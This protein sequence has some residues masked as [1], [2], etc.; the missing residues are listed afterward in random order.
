MIDYI[1]GK[2]QNPDEFGGLPIQH[3][4]LLKMREKVLLLL[5]FLLLIGCMLPP[6]D[7][8]WDNYMVPKWY[9]TITALLALVAFICYSKRVG[10]PLKWDTDKL[11]LVISIIVGFELLYVICQWIEH[12]DYIIT[13]TFDNPAGLALF[14]SVL[15]VSSAVLLQKS[16][17][18]N[19]HIKRI[20]RVTPITCLCIIIISKSRTG[21][22]VACIAL[23]IWILYK[24]QSSTRVKAPAIALIIVCIGTIVVANKQDSTIGR[25]FILQR[26]WDL[27]KEKPFLGH[28]HNGFRKEYMLRQAKYFMQNKESKY[29]IMADEIRHPL[30]EFL[31]VW[32]D[33]GLIGLLV[34][35]GF[36]IVPFVFC[37]EILPKLLSGV[38]FLFSLFSFPFAYPIS[39]VVAILILSFSLKPIWVKLFGMIPYF[40]S[41]TVWCGG[42][43]YLLFFL[44]VDI[45]FS[46][47]AVSASHHSHSNAIK[48]YQQIENSPFLWNKTEF[49]YNY[50]YELYQYKDFTKAYEAAKKCQSTWN[51][52]NLE[53]LMGD[54]S[55]HRD[56]NQWKEKAILH[57][58]TAFLM[59]PSRFAPLEG[60]YHAYLI[61]GDTI[62]ANEIVK[63]VRM[64][65]VKVPSSHIYRIKNELKEYTIK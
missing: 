50:A 14:A 43:I 15:G 8:C 28:G 27:I 51:G 62:H 37:K 59:C 26:T 64:K 9:V 6:I 55:V 56:G 36:F 20:L 47:A 54:I 52:Y 5:Q 22:I 24:W 23:T 40:L 58:K 25:Y 16:N 53:L 4:D 60:L 42:S 21:L 19:K 57:Y 10:K 65:R 7:Y 33:Y 34:F 41:A 13:G 11:L 44:F 35:L 31:L 12:S 48:K 17:E 39:F 45:Q 2:E 30:N 38:L 63:I 61:I 29:T 3:R 18:K 32:V 46:N 49:W 1:C